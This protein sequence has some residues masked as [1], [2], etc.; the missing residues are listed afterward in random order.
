M[1][2]DDLDANG[3][4]FNKILFGMEG[5]DKRNIEFKFRPCIPK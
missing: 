3:K 1:C 2:I 4:K 5:G